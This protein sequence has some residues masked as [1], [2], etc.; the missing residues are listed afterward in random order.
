MSRLLCSILGP[1]PPVRAYEPELSPPWPAHAP[2]RP[3]ESS[4]TRPHRDTPAIRKEDRVGRKDAHTTPNRKRNVFT[5]VPGPAKADDVALQ[6]WH[7]VISGGWAGL[8]P[9]PPHIRRGLSKSRVIRAR[10]EQH[11]AAP[12]STKQWQ[13]LGQAMRPPRHLLAGPVSCF[14]RATGRM[15][16]DFG[17]LPSPAQPSQCPLS[18]FFCHSAQNHK[19]INYCVLCII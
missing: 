9:A 17:C 8:G 15:Q 6:V 10:V 7:A 3:V 4:R 13:A 12:S 16:R 5:V 2:R 1:P 11:Q 14:S 18:P 19:L